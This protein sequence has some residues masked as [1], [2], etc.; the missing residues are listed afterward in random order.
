MGTSPQKPCKT[1]SA[2]LQSS[3]TILGATHPLH[4]P[5]ACWCLAH[6]LLVYFHLPT[7]WA[8]WGLLY[9]VV[10]VVVFVPGFYEI[11]TSPPQVFCANSDRIETLRPLITDNEKCNKQEQALLLMLHLFSLSVGSLLALIRHITEV[12]KASC[13]APRDSR[14]LKSTA[15]T[16]QFSP[17]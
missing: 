12:R 7:S 5:H 3:V 1:S 6:A 11:Q 15:E 10:V 14:V 9:F 4:V 17:S 8:D 13:L 16:Q 2:S